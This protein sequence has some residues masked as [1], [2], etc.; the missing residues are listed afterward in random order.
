MWAPRALDPKRRLVPWGTEFSFLGCLNFHALFLNSLQL[1][2]SF[3]SSRL[4][5]HHFKCHYK[6]SSSQLTHSDSQVKSHSHSDSCGESP[7]SFQT[8]ITHGK[9]SSPLWS[10]MLLIDKVMRLLNDSSVNLMGLTLVWH[11]LLSSTIHM[12]TLYTLSTTMLFDVLLLIVTL[13]IQAVFISSLI[14]AAWNFTLSIT[15]QRSIWWSVSLSLRTMPFKVLGNQVFWCSL[16]SDWNDS[17]PQVRYS[18]QHATYFS[19]NKPHHPW[20]MPVKNKLREDWTTDFNTAKL[21]V[22][23]WNEHHQINLPSHATTSSPSISHQKPEEA[24]SLKKKGT[25]NQIPTSNMKYSTPAWFAWQINVSRNF[26][27]A[28]MTHYTSFKKNMTPYLK[29]CFWSLRRTICC[30]CRVR[31][32]LN[33]DSGHGQCRKSEIR[34]YCGPA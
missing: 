26:C 5:S 14:H 33:T 2:T 4:I 12:N 34:A 22:L 28:S 30:C 19:L 11:Y 21:L 20:K 15:S 7:R 25:W 6:E 1:T 23:K 3:C 32:F 16:M 29:V 31:G 9:A 27:N 18:F 17:E 8:L 24:M 10:G 13:P